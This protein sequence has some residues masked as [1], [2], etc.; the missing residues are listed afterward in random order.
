M[1][2]A[3][4]ERGQ[5][6]TKVNTNCFSVIY[7][8]IQLFSFQL[9]YNYIIF[10]VW[11]IDWWC[12]GIPIP[13]FLCLPES[14]SRFFPKTHWHLWIFNSLLSMGNHYNPVDTRRWINVG[15][16]LVHWLRCWTNVKPTLIQH[17]V[18]AGNPVLRFSAVLLS[19][20]NTF[21]YVFMVCG[22]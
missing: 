17:I 7:L 11:L 22:K 20:R 18:S 16:K 9:Y 12:S 3:Q 21:W 14:E 4:T 2:C 1:T 13:E 6:N 8:H 19:L 5:L 15:L 10:I